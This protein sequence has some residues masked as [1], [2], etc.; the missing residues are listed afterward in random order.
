MVVLLVL[1]VLVM[2]LGQDCKLVQFTKQYLLSKPL[3]IASTTKPSIRTLLID[4][5]DSYT[6]NIWQ[7]LA[8]VNGIEPIVVYN[9]CYADWDTF[10]QNTDQ[11]DNI[12]IGPG[13]GSPLN[14]KDFGI[15]ADA[16]LKAQVPI[17]GVCLGHQGIAHMFGGEIKKA[18]E[19][20][21]GRLSHIMHS[22][23]DIFEDII[24]NTSVVRYHSLIV[25]NLPHDLMPIAWTSDKIVMGL[26]H[27]SLPI[28]GVQFH[29]ESV[30]TVCGD[31]IFKNFNKITKQSQKE[32]NNEK[33]N[34]IIHNLAGLTE[35][36]TSNPVHPIANKPLKTTYVTKVKANV[37]TESIFDLLFSNNMASFWLDSSNNHFNNNTKISNG[38]SSH[39]S[40]RF[41]FMGALDADDES[42]YAIEYLGHNNLVCR[43]T[44]GSTKSLNK[45]IFEYIDHLLTTETNNVT[46]VVSADPSI[47]A[48][49]KLPFGLQTSAIFGYLG[50]ELR[51]ETTHILTTSTSNL[52]GMKN[53]YNYSSTHQDSFSGSRYT[54]DSRHPLALYL[55]PT[56]YIVY[57]H[58]ECEAYVIGTCSDT[59][60]NGN[61][62]L[63]VVKSKVDAIATRIGALGDVPSYNSRDVSSDDVSDV[64]LTSIRNKETYS[65][66][67]KDCL[68]NIVN[69]ETY[70]VCLTL[71][72]QGNINR[73][74]VNPL[75]VYKRLR[76][77]NSSP[78]SSFIRYDPGAFTEYEVD[79]S[80]LLPWYK[81][82]GL[83]LCCSSPERYLSLDT[84]RCLESKPIKGTARRNINNH[85]EDR[86][87]ANKL[88]NDEKSRAENL[89]IVDL[90]NLPYYYTLTYTASYS[91]PLAIS[92]E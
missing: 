91:Y 9:D 17:L 59:T 27:K 79:K 85:Q 69:G 55:L 81:P 23:K 49:E 58:L 80:S 42:S 65:Q 37:S 75:H 57:D 1:L 25:D 20:M 40:N 33:L 46:S 22:G 82:G 34:D 83:S 61:Q 35:T 18:P 28:Y 2:F 84:S 53:R 24:Q 67:I 88:I 66:N 13:P 41:S 19:P 21:H 31:Q 30:S 70:E 73:K 51:H 52:A 76:R 71:Q 60:L 86:I 5:Y 45:N 50:Y 6:Y 78:L 64:V 44:N 4:N 74:R 39:T 56:S 68:E 11:F 32:K 36:L 48:V 26:K 12:V 43:W 3:N 16:I 10:L 90:G 15:S 72:F 7:S 92:A 87:I 29:P 77:Q 8:R 14:H 62:Q 89:L 38:I 63:S 47:G 54:S